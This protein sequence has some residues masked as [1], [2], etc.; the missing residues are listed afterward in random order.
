MIDSI[1]ELLAELRGYVAENM[2][3]QAYMELG[4]YQKAGDT[5]IKVL[6]V[7]ASEVALVQQLPKVDRIFVKHLKS[8][9]KAIEIYRNVQQN[10]E[11]SKLKEILG[12]KIAFLEANEGK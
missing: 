8:P 12:K 1:D 9:D 2:L 11:N 10:T 4:D 3:M 7:Y 6:R 5:L